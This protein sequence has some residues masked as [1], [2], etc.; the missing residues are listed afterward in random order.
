M[1]IQNQFAN[2]TKIAL[3]SY[4]VIDW[5][6]YALIH[7]QWINVE[8]TPNVLHQIMVSNAIVKQDIQATLF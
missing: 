1:A 3:L 2:I 7:A 4:Y 6:E 8:T 5:T